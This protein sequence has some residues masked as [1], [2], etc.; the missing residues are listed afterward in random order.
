MLKQILADM[1]ID[2]ELLA[3]L[4]EEQ[5]QIL[6]FKMREEQI[7]RWK[8][9]EAT[10]EQNADLTRNS[11][12]KA[13][14]KTVCWK[15]GSDQEVW[16]WVMGEH[17]SDK[18]YDV[19]CDEIINEH[20]RELAEKEAE[21][22]RKKQEEEFAKLPMPPT[23]H[24]KNNTISRLKEIE[25]KNLSNEDFIIVNRQEMNEENQSITRRSRTVEDILSS[26]TNQIKSH[27]FERSQE[28]EN[29]RLQERTQEIYMN[30]KEAQEV[31]QKLEKED[32][33]WQ[34]SLRKSKAADQ[35]RRSVAKQARDDY[36]RLSMQAI[37]QGSVSEKAKSFGQV[38]R[39]PLPPKPKFIT[40]TNNNCSTNRLERRQG[41]RRLNSSTTRDNIIKWFKDEQIPLGAG[42][43]KSGSYIEPWFHGIISRQEAEELLKTKGRGSFLLR[44]S[45][46]IQGY[47]LSYCS[48]EGCAHFLIDAS[49]TTYSFLG[50]DQL[51]HAALADLVEYHKTEPI[52]SMGRELLLYP[53]AQRTGVCDY[54]DLLE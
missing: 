3:E 49:G 7:K 1:Y 47:V 10:N 33:E 34:E 6:F 32:A 26:A 52:P 23:L 39:P 46:K 40:T 24:S 36:K 35:R 8:E 43:D 54:N 15:L 30:W 2:P 20:A 19:I 31:K 22:L 29:D 44:V 21:E 12:Q 5:K 16:V 11:R 51:Q 48:E 4:S 37:E 42:W 25:N 41:I 14:K 9:R 13:S 38:K 45:E 27:G 18:P 53:C 28:K 50:V 17:S